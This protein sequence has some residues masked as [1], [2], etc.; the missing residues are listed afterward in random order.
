MMRVVMASPRTRRA[1]GMAAA[2]AVAVSAAACS[3]GTGHPGGPA[4]PSAVAENKLPGTS[5]WRITDQGP[6]DAINGYASAQSVLPGQRFT[7]YVSTTARSFRVDAFR[8]GYYHGHDARLV[9]TSPPVRGRLQTA[10]RIAPGTHMVTAPWQPSL[11]V[12]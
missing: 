8:F 3:A 1:A 9:W 12:S 2:L 5:A 7:L 4:A 6:A 10:V 11:T